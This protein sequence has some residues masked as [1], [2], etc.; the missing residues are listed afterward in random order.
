MANRR[1]QDVQ[2][3]EREVKILGTTISGVDSGT[4]TATPSLGISK[5]EQAGGD[6]TITLLDK[7]N[8]LLCAQV[9]LGDGAGG[10]GALTA[11]KVKSE[12]VDGAKTVVIDT[13]GSANANDELHVTLLLKNTSVAR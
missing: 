1:F 12:D 2:A 10:A 3:V 8:Q 6:V 13:T 4:C 7:Y 9:T 11:A 5:V